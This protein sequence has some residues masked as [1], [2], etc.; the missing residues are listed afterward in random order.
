LYSPSSC[1]RRSDGESRCAFVRPHNQ[2]TLAGLVSANELPP[3]W[4]AVVSDAA[5]RIIARSEQEDAFLGKE[6]PP[7]QWHPTGPGGVFEF[8]D[9]EGRSLLEAHARSE[10]TGWESAR[11]AT[12]ALL[13][14]Q[15]EPC[16]NDRGVHRDSDD[17]AYAV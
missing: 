11:W 7:A 16:R 13:E 6:L 15:A 14:R 12:K 8:I 3:G 5:H 2:H 9:A 1:Q 4:R 10:L 17:Y